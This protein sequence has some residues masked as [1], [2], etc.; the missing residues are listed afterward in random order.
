MNANLEK[1]LKMAKITTTQNIE[2]KDNLVLYRNAD[3]SGYPLAKIYD[4]MIEVLWL[5]L[6]DIEM[7]LY[8]RRNQYG[9]YDWID[10]INFT[11]LNETEFELYAKE[12]RESML[13]NYK[14]AKAISIARAQFWKTYKEVLGVSNG[15]Y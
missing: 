13:K 12:L 2:I 6:N 8:V 3:G 7:D 14:M 4:T 10:R 1:L 15:N 9:E 5:E 11:K